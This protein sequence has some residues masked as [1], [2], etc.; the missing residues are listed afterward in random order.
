MT[1]HAYGSASADKG[2]FGYLRKSLAALAVVCGVFAM[3]AGQAAEPAQKVKIAESIRFIGFLPAYVAKE[4]GYFAEEGLDVEFI[5]TGSRT[6]CF[7]ALV[8]GQADYCGSDPAGAALARRKGAEV[9]AVLPVAM[10][11]QNYLLVTGDRP[12]QG[13]EMLRGL[14]VAM[15]NPPWTGSALFTEYLKSQGFVQVDNTTWKPKDSN[16]PKDQL[17]MR[18][19]NFFTEMPQVYAKNANAVLV[20]PPY[21]A[22]AQRE[23]GMKV[24]VSWGQNAGPYLFTTLNT[25]D[26]N[27]KKNPKQVQA[28]ANAFAKTFKF[29][30]E[31]PDEVEKIAEKWFPSIHPEVIKLVV[32]RMYDEGV[33]PLDTSIPQ[34]AYD[35]NINGV[36]VEIGDEAA[37]TPYTELVDTTFAERAA[38][39]VK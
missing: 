35:R 11:A 12:T 10:R 24:A 22:M 2:Y 20:V 34:A 38:K 37:K 13:P 17:K 7:Q 19:V 27:I 23:L 15:A 9:K 31:H 33:I 16:D 32:K 39:S 5:V 36:L 29:A 21:E 8:A 18:F 28:V 1:S 14:T 4:K 26:A 3:P 25:T 6:L 30:K